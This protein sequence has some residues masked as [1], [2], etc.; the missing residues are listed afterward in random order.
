[1]STVSLHRTA[2]HRPSPPPPVIESITGHREPQP[3]FE[4]IYILM[5]TTHN[6]DRIIRDFAPARQQYA[7]AHLFFID[8]P[9]P[10]PP[11][12]RRYPC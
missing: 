4:A 5:P 7:A 11:P 6:V 8:G 3:A 12:A 1:M 10:P 2:P 9:S